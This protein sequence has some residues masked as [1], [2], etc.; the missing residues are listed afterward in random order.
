MGIQGRLEGPLNGEEYPEVG[1][2]TFEEWVKEQ[3]WSRLN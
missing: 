1:W 3:D 2:H